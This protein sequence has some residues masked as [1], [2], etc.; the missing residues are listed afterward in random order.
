M[1]IALWIVAGLAAAA[2]LMAGAMKLMQGKKVEE[3]GMAWAKHY[4]DAAIRS[5]GAAEVAGAL[6]LILP[7]VTGIATWLVPTAA[8]GLVI[9]M[10]GAVRRHVVDGEGAKGSMPAAVLGILALIV[11]IGRIWVAP[12]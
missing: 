1:N 2:F 8:I 5:I 7:A 12:F 11:A 9:V 4:S 10:V 3:K 6:G